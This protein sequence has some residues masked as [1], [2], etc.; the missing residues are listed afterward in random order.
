[1]NK[2]WKKRENR[3][4]QR[5][6]RNSYSGEAGEILKNGGIRET[7]RENSSPTGS[8]ITHFSCG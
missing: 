1:M 7:A 3:H 4:E 8:L 2:L 6:S 5:V